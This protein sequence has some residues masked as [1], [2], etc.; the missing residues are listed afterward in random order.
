MV[1]ALVLE[2]H[3]SS[4]LDTWAR[5]VLADPHLPS[6][7]ALSR[8]ALFDH[9]PEIV[10]LLVAALRTLAEGPEALGRLVG[11]MEEAQ[12]QVRRRIEAEYSLPE[13]L[14]ELSHLRFAILEVCKDVLP[15]WRS[16]GI[17]HAA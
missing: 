1:L 8:P 5:R 11:D 6:A 2:T 4:L 16:A 3:Q 9:F 12:S 13:L 10:D 14:R 17:L 15:D 7:A